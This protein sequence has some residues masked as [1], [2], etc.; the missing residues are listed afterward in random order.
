MAEPGTSFGPRFKAAF[1]DSF[2]GA[3][4]AFALFSFV[5]GLR[6]V[7]SV[8]GLTLQPRPVL[9]AVA[10]GTVFFGRLLLNLFVWQADHPLTAPLRQAVQL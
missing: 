1:A 7:D 4:I 2:L 3:I 10:V 5:L 6:T 8:T 9:L